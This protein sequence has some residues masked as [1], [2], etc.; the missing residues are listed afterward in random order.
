MKLTLY[1]LFLRK[2]KDKMKF[3]ELNIKKEILSAVE[4]KGFESMTDI[5]A[6]SIPVAL[7]GKDILGQA[8]TGTGKTAAF[9]IP[10]VNK[11][12]LENK[13]V[14]ALILVPTREL[15]LQVAK[16]LNSL[17]GSLPIKAISIY[18]GDPMEKQLREL[19]DKP[20]IVVAT[21]GRCIDLINR[22]KLKVKNLKFF[23]LDEVDEMLNMGFIDDVEFISSVMPETKQ[24]LLFSATM[25]DKIKNI[26]SKYLVE[27]HIIKVKSKSIVADRV[28]QFYI[29]AK[30]KQKNLVLKNLVDLNNKDKIIIFTQTKR[31]ADEVSDF[32]L[33]YGLLVGKIHGDLP[34]KART[35]TIEKFRQNKIQ[36]LVATDVVAR[37]IDID[38]VDLVVNYELPQDIEYYIHRIGRTARGSS[39]KGKA[40]T[41][42]TPNAYDKE[43]RHY[44]K[45][46]KV[47]IKELPQP[48]IGEVISILKEKYVK[49]L[50]ESKDI[51]EP[52]FFEMA[53]EIMEQKEVYQLLAN[54]LFEK[55]PQLSKKENLKLVEK[56]ENNNGSRNSRNRGS[57]NSKGSRN[58]RSNSDN[59][60]RRNDGRRDNGSF[61]R[62]RGNKRKNK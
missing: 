27:P 10:I 28:E 40:I 38:N 57:N 21:P 55:Y 54:L 46:L 49:Q 25:P 16:E 17:A 50:V 19:R 43:F 31:S 37:G 7:K 12:E 1:K 53:H 9:G 41:L 51:D 39:A 5:Q 8:Q 59:K 35:L 20:Q 30:A 48:K 22:N 14:Q 3:N 47:E 32:L 62:G 13:N 18:G 45:K 52:I 2:E 34:Q 23:A 11:I 61:K 36:Y 58:R 44:S 33:S 60:S 56:S 24:T 29:K 6:E 15:A 42:V 4:A 26:A